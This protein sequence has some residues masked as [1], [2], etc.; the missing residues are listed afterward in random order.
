MLDCVARIPAGT[1]QFL[2]FLS[3]VSEKDWYFASFFD[4]YYAPSIDFYHS[5]PAETVKSSAELGSFPYWAGE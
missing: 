3:E 2:F 1:V 5:Y 4:F